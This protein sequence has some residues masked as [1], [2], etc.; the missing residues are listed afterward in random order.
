MD[1]ERSWV[2]TLA[3]VL[4]LKMPDYFGEEVGRR[5]LAADPS[6]TVHQHLLVSKQ[7]QVLVDILREV[8]EFTDVW[9]QAMCKLSLGWQIHPILA[10]RYGCG[11][12]VYIA[13]HQSLDLQ[14]YSR[15]SYGSLTRWCRSQSSPPPL[16]LQLLYGT[17]LAPDELLQ[18][19]QKS[20]TATNY[21]ST[22]IRRRAKKTGQK[23]LAPP[24]NE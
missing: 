1:K 24:T 3:W 22:L 15:K 19:H 23:A 16:K 12:I 8:T 9:G 6:S 2:A 5:A 17:P 20:I 18:G 21:Y 13:A 10:A 4:A 14:F 7:V 11:I